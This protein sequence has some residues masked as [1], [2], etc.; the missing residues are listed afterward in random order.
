MN[1]AIDRPTVEH[2]RYSVERSATGGKFVANVTEFRP[3]PGWLAGWL[4]LNWMRLAGW[5]FS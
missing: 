2:Y 5:G 1:A 4:A 3:F